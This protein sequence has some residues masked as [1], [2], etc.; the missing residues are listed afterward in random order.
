MFNWKISRPFNFS[1]KSDFSVITTTTMLTF[2]AFLGM[3]SATIPSGSVKRFCDNRKK[4]YD[5][6][7]A[8]HRRYLYHQLSIY[9]GHHPS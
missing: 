4:S 3:E 8:S 9:H 1:G 6:R 2:F 5:F 7:D